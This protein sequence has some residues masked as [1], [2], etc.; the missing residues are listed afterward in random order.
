MTRND[1]TS[2]KVV[3]EG[4]YL[5]VAAPLENDCSLVQS[6]KEEIMRGLS[7]DELSESIE[8]VADGR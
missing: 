5:S 3:I 1:M 7:P 8:L 4:E 6:S 2:P